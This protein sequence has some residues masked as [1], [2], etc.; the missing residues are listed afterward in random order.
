MRMD[1]PVL[2]VL[3]ALAVAAQDLLPGIPGGSIK[4]PFLLGVAVYYALNRPWALAL[5]AAVWSGWLTDGPGGLPG[6]CTS[7]FL[8]LL[9]LGLRPMRKLFLDGSCAGVVAASAGAAVLEALWQ[10]SW[11]R[12]VWPG[13]GWRMAGG[14]ALLLPAGAIAGA[15]AWALGN[16]LDRRAGNVKS[17]E[18][19]HGTA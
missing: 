15:C 17:R 6:A 12:L 9:A 10:L 16:G 19:I 18:E 14:F 3:L 8:L 11:A 7:M 5:L 1:L 4:I 13:G 2:G